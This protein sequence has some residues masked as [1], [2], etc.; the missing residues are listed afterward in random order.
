MRF[1]EAAFARRVCSVPSTPRRTSPTN[2]TF[3]Y[4]RRVRRISSSAIHVDSTV[5]YIGGQATHTHTH[6]FLP[7]TTADRRHTHTTDTR[8]TCVRVLPPS[9]IRLQTRT[10]NIP[11]PPSITSLIL[12]L[13]ICYFHHLSLVTS[14]RHFCIEGA[15]RV[16]SPSAQAVVTGHL[17]P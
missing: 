9:T 10:T 8:F 7:A 6:A 14:S 13:C 2:N 4:G 5:L 12:N 17:Q 1:L 3:S 16:S 15:S 11:P